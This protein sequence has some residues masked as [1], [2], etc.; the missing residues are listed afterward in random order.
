ML[1]AN[2]EPLV[3]LYHDGFLRVSLTEYDPNSKDSSVHLTNT[4]LAKEFLDEAD[5]LDMGEKEE[6]M[7][8]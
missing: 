6:I 4:A 5:D 3:I 1:I 7:R 2:I 8:E